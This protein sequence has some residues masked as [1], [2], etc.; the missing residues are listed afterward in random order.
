M[1]L[2]SIAIT[3]SL[4]LLLV[5]WT[6]ASIITADLHQRRLLAERVASVR[7]GPR[8]TATADARGLGLAVRLRAVTAPVLDP[9]LGI[10]R[11]TASDEPMSLV[12]GLIV[13]AIAGTSLWVVVTQLFELPGA[14]AFALGLVFGWKAA[15][16]AVGGKRAAI[17]LGMEDAFSH[18]LSVIVRCVRA[19][20]PV[21]EGMRAVA[22][23]VPAPTGPEFR[24][25]VDQIQLGES[26]DDALYAL[27][28]RCALPEYRFFAVSVALQRQTG[29]NLGETLENLA[30]TLR[31]RKA[32]RLKAQAL[33]SEPKATVLVLS[34]LPVAVGMLMMVVNPP[35][36]LQ[37]F[38]TLSGRHLLG[39]AIVV[40]AIGLVIIRAIIK[41]TLS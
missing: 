38:T 25:C 2:L 24:R 34:I 19:G 40:Q 21:A 15:R 8:M 28:D 18:A 9:I 13:W 41:T 3:L 10:D 30:D 5:A 32:I 22:T 17:R 4:P 39:A 33:T 29:G 20:L 23:E 11:R 14:T 26:F 31:K 35:Y 7:T 37:L 6:G 36:I 1:T 12:P 27:A 16:M